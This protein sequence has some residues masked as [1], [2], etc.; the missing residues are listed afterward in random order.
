MDQSNSSFMTIYN[1]LICVID[2]ISI[3]VNGRTGYLEKQT[4]PSEAPFI[5]LLAFRTS[6]SVQCDVGFSDHLL[7]VGRVIFELVCEVIG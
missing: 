5:C 7:P 3:E 6:Q 1:F 2:S 4:A